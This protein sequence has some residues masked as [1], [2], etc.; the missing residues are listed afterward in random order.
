MT[1]GS[2]TKRIEKAKVPITITIAI[3]FA[4]GGIA[5]CSCH[6]SIVG[7]KVGL[8]SS[9]RCSRAEPRR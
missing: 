2:I 4:R 9:Q 5:P 1:G 7:P 8:V 6:A 3:A